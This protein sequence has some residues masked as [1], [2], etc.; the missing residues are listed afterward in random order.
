MRVGGLLDRVGRIASA[1]AVD[2][3]MGLA[4]EFLEVD[5]A[6]V[7]HSDARKEEVHEHGLAAADAAEEVEPFRAIAPLA[8]E[9]REKPRAGGQAR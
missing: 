4:H 3:L 5:A 8:Q 9:G 6:L 7:A 1:G 2:Q